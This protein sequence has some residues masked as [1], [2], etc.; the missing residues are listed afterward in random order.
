MKVLF[1]KGNISLRT[2]MNI[3]KKEKGNFEQEK[4]ENGQ[5]IKEII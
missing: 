1:G 5:F 4:P 2:T 3:I